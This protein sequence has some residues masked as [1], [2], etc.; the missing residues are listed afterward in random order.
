M[1][2]AT[3][4][5]APGVPV[6]VVNQGSGFRGRV[7]SVLHLWAGVHHE[8]VTVAFPGSALAFSFDPSEL[9]VL[10]PGE[11]QEMFGK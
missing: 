11:V 3:A 10:A 9:R 4:G 2:A 6:A 8:V 1:K 5:L 7:G